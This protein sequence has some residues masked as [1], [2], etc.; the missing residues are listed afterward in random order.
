VTEPEALR[1]FLKLICAAC[2]FWLAVGWI[3]ITLLHSRI[4]RRRSARRHNSLTAIAK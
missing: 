4:R 1:L 3:T 2:L